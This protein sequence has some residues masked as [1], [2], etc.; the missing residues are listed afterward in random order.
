M[1]RKKFYDKIREIVETI[2]RSYSSASARNENYNTEKI[3]NALSSNGDMINILTKRVNALESKVDSLNTNE[4][5]STDAK[6]VEEPS[7]TS[8]ESIETED[9]GTKRK[10]RYTEA[11]NEFIKS[12]FEKGTPISVIHQKYISKFG[13]ERTL[14]T[15]HNH[16][17]RTL[18]LRKPRVYKFKNGGT[19]ASVNTPDVTPVSVEVTTPTAGSENNV[20]SG[21]WTI[22]ETEIATR[23]YII[24]G[25]DFEYIG[26]M[27][28]RSAHAVE[29]KLSKQNVTKLFNKERKNHVT[30]DR[31][32][33]PYTD[34]EKE[35][36]ARYLSMGTLSLYVI[37]Y[38]MNRK[39][40]AIKRQATLMGYKQVTRGKNVYFATKN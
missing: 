7:N 32:N 35:K 19:T 15:F 26:K 6:E 24:N 4:A 18:K 27:L 20:R 30:E 13:V 23:W 31:T 14:G 10:N 22:E 21:R 33:A 5:P 29:C 28:N 39:E 34:K 37:A 12:E 36:L 3:L 16:I 9:S 2:V 40:G 1:F 11:Q 38:M 17:T 25:Y 8:G